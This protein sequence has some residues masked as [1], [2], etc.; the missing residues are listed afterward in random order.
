MFKSIVQF[1]TRTV[2][3]QWPGNLMK[4]QRTPL[5]DL[6]FQLSQSRGLPS[7]TSSRSTRYS[8][9]PLYLGDLIFADKAITM[10]G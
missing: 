5:E 3:E 6:R 10:T 1:V 8:K 2:L 4:T 9:I 7:T